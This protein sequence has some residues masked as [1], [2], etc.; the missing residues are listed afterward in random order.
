MKSF[1]GSPAAVGCVLLAVALAG[2]DGGTTSAPSTVTK[3]VYT[4]S[5]VPFPT[6]SIP[7]STAVTTTAPQPATATPQ[8]ATPHYTVLWADQRG[9]KKINTEY[10]VVIDPVDLSN[11]SFKQNVKLILR[12]IATNN[13]WHGPNFS[14]LIFDNEAAARG[15]I[16][17][18]KD[19]SSLT[20]S[21]VDALDALSL[22]HLVASY[23]GGINDAAQK[24]TADDAYKISWFYL[25][26]DD[27]PTVGKYVSN[28][29]WKP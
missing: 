9:G 25:A 10:Y 8:P 19:A 3:T 14:A 17:W 20:D 13:P 6:I 26:P 23:M 4:S 5:T 12:A 27:N 21:E 18:T 22:V 1:V 24:S 11:D 29:Q 2:C 16:S 28:E 7:T 15:E